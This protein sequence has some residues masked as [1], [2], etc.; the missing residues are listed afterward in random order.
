[1][2]TNAL[3]LA[4]YKDEFSILLVV[5]LVCGLQEAVSEVIVAH[6]RWRHARSGDGGVTACFVWSDISKHLCTEK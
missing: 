4:E 3:Q 2:N 6:L 1:M 5:F